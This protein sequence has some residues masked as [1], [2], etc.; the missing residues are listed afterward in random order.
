[1]MDV[2][3]T[4]RYF[5]RELSVLDFQARVLALAENPDVPLLERAKF[6]AIVS[7]NLDEFFQVRVA[8]LKE[9]VVSGVAATSPDGMTPDAQLDAIRRKVVPLMER[10]DHIFMKSLLPE[11]EESGIRLADYSQLAGDDRKELDEIFESQIYPVL[12]P[13]AV[14]PAHPFPYISNLSLNLAVLTADPVDGDIQFARVK[15]PPILPRFI[16]LADGERFVPLEQVIAHHVD[17]LFPG[18]EV[19]AHHAFRVTRN[20]DLAIEEDEAED[21]LDA[22]ETVL[23]MRQRFSRAVQL[24]IHP[25]MSPE[26]LDLLMRELKLDE[27]ELYVSEA[28]LDLA[29]L[30]ALHG[31]NRPDLKDPPWTPTTQ[32]RLAQAGPEAPDFFEV[33]RKGDVLVHM[34]YES[35]ATSAG[36]FLAQA[37]ADPHV[38]AIK[39]TLYRTSMPDDPAKGGEESVV[40]SL[41]AAAQSGKQV[42]CL[43]ELKAR[44]DEQANIRWARLL[45]EAGVHVV[46]GVMG[47][48]THSKVSLVVRKEGTELRRYSNVGTGNYNPKTARIYEDLALFTCDPDIGADLSELFNVLTGGG[49]RT[50]YRKLLVAPTTLRLGLLQLIDQQAAL[51]HDGRL[52]FKINHLLDTAMIDALY[53]ASGAGVQ[54]DL[55]VRGI[56]ALQPGVPGVSENIRVRSLVGRYLEHSRIYRFGEPGRDA[57]YYLGSADLMPRNLSGRV[58]A[59][60]PVEDPALQQRIERVLEV[61]LE[62]DVLAWRLDSDG[63]WHKVDQYGGRNAHERFQELALDNTRPALS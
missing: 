2:D 55:I 53:K 5:N 60:A 33:L 7:G 45:E 48:K 20:A 28:P 30:W 13:L 42:V 26:A 57:S 40:R 31:L 6:V 35:F 36:A 23:Q 17:R 8:G 46:Y 22:M 47:L 59:L 29:G 52:V 9:Q 14:D 3:D 27:D 63:T 39:Q 12:T 1:M 62:D 11:L 43:V 41:I 50:D 56:C 58:E 10:R 37:A 25:D 34:P 54:I 18:R 24:E 4:T 32:A 38:L 19:V 61:N 21:L 15:V 44:F 16:V 51:G 49:V